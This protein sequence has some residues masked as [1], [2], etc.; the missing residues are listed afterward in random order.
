MAITSNYPAIR[1]SLNLDFANAKALDPRITFSRASAAT[2]SDGKTVAKA[3][4]NLL[5]WSQDFD[6][7]VWPKTNASVAANVA[8][9]PDGTNTADLLT[10]SSD[11][12]CGIGQGSSYPQGQTVLSIYAKAATSS[13]IRLGVLATGSFAWFDLT[14][15]VAGTVQS[16]A[17]ATIQSVGNGWFRCV[18][19]VTGAPQPVIRLANADNSVN[20][21]TGNSVYIWGAQL[22]QRSQVTAYTP[23]TTQPITNYI[24]VLQTAPA[25]VPRFD[26][27]PVT[28]ESLGL[29]VEEQ[30]TNLLTYSEQLDNATWTKVGS[31]VASAVR[32]AP[33]GELTGAKLV[34]ATDTAS[35]HRVGKSFTATS[36]TAYSFSVYLKKSERS[37]VM[38]Q[39]SSATFSEAPPASE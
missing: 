31:T 3:E 21:T 9:A 32:T 12:F 34:E 17:L 19:I 36:G 10:A 14:T 6:S 25:G 1:P 29:L 38:L 33:S 22:E 16:G 35:T 13:I 7:T 8:I 15:G 37:W 30:R 27:S 24:P 39:F 23:T 20:A 18:L 26:H 28:G 5:V 4:E 11:T 2:Y